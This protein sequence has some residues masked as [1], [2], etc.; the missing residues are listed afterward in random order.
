MHLLRKKKYSLE[1]IGLVL[2]R[3]KS[4][5]W[6]ELKR[7]RTRGGYDPQKA[8]H[9]AYVR[10]RQSK[11]QAKKIVE[12]KELKKFVEE[13]LYDGQS[14]NNIAGRI[15]KKEK[16]FPASQKKAST[17]TSEVYTEE[18]LKCF[19]TRGSTEKGVAASR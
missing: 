8:E 13:S 18:G 19:E 3:A 5:I 12:H 1:D 6:N 15:M 7:N 9:K 4:A 2:G 14:P 17:G 11:Y 16:T 10:R